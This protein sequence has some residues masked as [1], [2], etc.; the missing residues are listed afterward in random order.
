VHTAIDFPYGN[1]LKQPTIANRIVLG[2]LNNIERHCKRI[3]YPIRQLITY[4]V[5]ARFAYLLQSARQFN[6]SL[7]DR[8]QLDPS[9][10][11]IPVPL[12]RCIDR[13]TLVAVTASYASKNKK[14]EFVV[15]GSVPKYQKYPGTYPRT[16]R[17]PQRNGPE[18]PAPARPSQNLYKREQAA[19]LFNFAALIGH[20]C[21]THT[22]I[23]QQNT[24]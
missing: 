9:Y 11:C 21:L 22:T 13:G 8:V 6:N 19:L 5:L 20:R 23:L 2:L 16:A 14:S 4:I 15:P 12:Y 17:T 1:N 24:T 10:L 7:L 18:I 3:N